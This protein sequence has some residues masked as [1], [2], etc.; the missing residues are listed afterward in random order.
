MKSYKNLYPQIYDFGNL[1]A[2]FRA[3]RKGKRNRAAVASYEFDLEHNLLELETDLKQ[4]TYTPG[5]YTNFYIYEPKRRLVSAAPFKDRVV[6]H[7]LCNIIEPIWEPRFIH[8]S[9]ACRVGKGTHQALDQA[10]AWV[11]KYRYVFH[12]DIVKYFPSIDHQII[13]GLLAR[14]I[15]D[16]QTMWLIDQIL[17]SGAGI[18]ADEAP[19]TWFPGDDLFAAIR[20]RGL[21][22][23]NLTS[24]FWANVYLHELDSF[25]K[26]QLG[27]KAYQRYMDDFLL[28]SH[29]KAQLHAWKEAIRTFLASK[30]RLVLHPAKSL[31][32]PVKVGLDFCGFRLYPTHR[33]LRRSSVRRFVQRFRRQRQAYQAGELTLAEWQISI[34]CWIAHAAHGNTWRLRRRIFRDYPLGKPGR[35]PSPA[36]A[37][38]L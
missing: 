9:F 19:L 38:S 5:A 12:G 34:R 36:E 29:D 20:P 22:I 14:R 2:A 16:R 18:Q 4:Q 11:K 17:N 35:Q 30:L 28:F 13:R 3:A 23:G 33:R 25:V 32:F 24:Q 8:T 37:F 21:P 7:A 1:Y 26:H 27:C 6:H 31:V 10:H 15:A